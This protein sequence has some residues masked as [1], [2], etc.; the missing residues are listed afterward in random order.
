[1]TISICIAF[2]HRFTASLDAIFIVI[3]FLYM[4]KWRL[5]ESQEIPLSK[6]QSWN[7]KLV[8]TKPD[9]PIGKQIFP[10]Q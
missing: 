2:Y 5:R 8:L 4:K 6:W 1:M 7:E 10:F 3:L 9:A